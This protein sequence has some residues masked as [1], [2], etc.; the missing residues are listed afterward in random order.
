MRKYMEEIMTVNQRSQKSIQS[1]RFI[2]FISIGLG[3][4]RCPNQNDDK[5][6]ILFSK[7]KN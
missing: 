6:D 7:E 2:E 3:K 4:E 1:Y 5:E